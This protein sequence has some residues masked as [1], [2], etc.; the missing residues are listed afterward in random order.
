MHEAVINKLESETLRLVPMILLL[1][2]DR[3]I[4]YFILNQN[5]VDSARI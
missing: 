5:L 3:C 1:L 4:L 2:F